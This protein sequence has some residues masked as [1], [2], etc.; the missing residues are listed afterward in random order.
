[1]VPPKL[2]REKRMD[3]MVRKIVRGSIAEGQAVDIDA[4]VA[5]VS[6]ELPELSKTELS[7]VIVM[8]ARLVGQNV[9]WKSR[10]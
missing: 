10:N 4:A 1:M 5:A 3:R 8:A 6:K 2:D 9:V 7:A